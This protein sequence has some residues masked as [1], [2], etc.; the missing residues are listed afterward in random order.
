MPNKRQH[1]QCGMAALEMAQLLRAHWTHLAT[2]NVG[3][4][5]YKEFVQ[6]CVR[7]RHPSLHSVP[8]DHEPCAQIAV[9]WRQISEPLDNVFWVHLM[10]ERLDC[11]S[12]PRD[13]FHM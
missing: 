10:G 7:V 6:V 3:N 4:L 2:A 9:D 1:L 5:R 12:M 8:T 11:R 13:L